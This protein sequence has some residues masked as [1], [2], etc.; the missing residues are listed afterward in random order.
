MRSEIIEITIDNATLTSH[1][2]ITDRKRKITELPPHVDTI[3]LS[4]VDG[5]AQD[6]ENMCEKSSDITTSYETIRKV[7]DVS[8][9]SKL[10][11]GMNIIYY[12]FIL[13]DI[14]FILLT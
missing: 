8:S 9:S 1:H 4:K 12:I 13:G 2:Q 6:N 5:S 7:S 10:S 11:C 14:K 3:L